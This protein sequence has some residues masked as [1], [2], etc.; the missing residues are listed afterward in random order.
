M[1]SALEERSRFFLATII[2][3]TV[4]AHE[5]GDPGVQFNEKTEGRKSRDT[6]PLKELTVQKTHFALCT[7][8]SNVSIGKLPAY[9]NTVEEK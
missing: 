3:K 8:Y 4:L 6:V 9:Q 7:L 2:C 5:S 1:N